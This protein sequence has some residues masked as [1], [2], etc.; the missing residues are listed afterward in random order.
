MRGVATKLGYE[1]GEAMDGGYFDEYIKAFNGVS[2]RAVVQ[3]SG[4][5]LP[6]ENVPAAM[7]SLRFVKAAKNRAT[8]LKL[9]EVPDVL[10]SECWNDY[11]AMA[12]KGAFDEGWEKKMPW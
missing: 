8:E 3:F 9:S 6:E 11:H 7:I 10:L 1:R 5:C 12:E 4:N 2:I